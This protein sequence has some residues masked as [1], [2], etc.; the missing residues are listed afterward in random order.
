M[1]NTQLW[2]AVASVLAVVLPLIFG[3]AWWREKSGT[4]GKIFQAAVLAA[5][6]RRNTDYLDAVRADPTQAP[7]GK[8][9]DNI[10]KEARKSAVDEV[11]AVL[12][13]AAQTVG[14]PAGAIVQSLVPL[15]GRA[16]DATVEAI[17]EGR[18][19]TLPAAS[20][21]RL[22]GVLLLF[23]LALS[24][25]GCSTLPKGWTES[26]PDAWDAVAVAVCERVYA[27][28][29]STLAPVPTLAATGRTGAITYQAMRETKI[30]KGL[31][32]AAAVKAMELRAKTLPAPLVGYE[33]IAAAV[34]EVCAVPANDA[35][36]CLGLMVGAIRSPLAP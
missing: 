28:D 10:A 3:T 31:C 12:D 16:I 30:D 24:A 25:A 35:D 7:I 17:K 1:D 20:A 21:A 18:N 32:A 8:L 4:V 11:T 9:P 2:A 34:L 22:P 15:A 14:G 13:A 36:Q 27:P 29:A 19:P 26:N 33:E 6:N 5:V 23:A